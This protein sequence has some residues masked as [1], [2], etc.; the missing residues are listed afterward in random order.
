MS[1]QGAMNEKVERDQVWREKD[2]RFVRYVRVIERND[3]WV[4]IRSCSARG[5]DQSL[6]RPTRCNRARFVKA[7]RLI[8]PQGS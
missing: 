2:G 8:S 3:E 5:Y 7:F 1:E 6:R 4:F